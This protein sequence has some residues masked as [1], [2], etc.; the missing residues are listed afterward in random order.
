M[1]DHKVARMSSF[2]QN[3]VFQKV[4]STISR[5]WG[6]DTTFSGFLL[7]VMGY[8]LVDLSLYFLFE[9]FLELLHSGYFDF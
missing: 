2:V 1:T 4:I 8:F 3:T 6:G 9:Y 5:I 7:S